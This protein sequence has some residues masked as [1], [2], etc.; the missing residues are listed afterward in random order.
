MA[1]CGTS[2]RECVAIATW[3]GAAND[4]AAT[5]SEQLHRTRVSA[6]R[7]HSRVL[8]VS[9]AKSSDEDV[10]QPPNKRNK[11]KRPYG[12][13]PAPP[14]LVAK[15]RDVHDVLHATLEAA[16]TVEAAATRSAHVTPNN[17][18]DTSANRAAIAL[19]M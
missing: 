11:I 14:A 5:A 13:T 10:R 12:H 17:T 19:R 2:L 4:V 8:P 15:P 16:A 7:Q 9:P 1:F 18:N 3:A 6:P